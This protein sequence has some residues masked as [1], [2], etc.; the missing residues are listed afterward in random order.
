MGRDLLWN[1]RNLFYVITKMG[2][3]PIGIAKKLGRDLLFNC[4]ILSSSIIAI[5]SAA[6]LAYRLSQIDLGSSA[7]K[8]GSESYWNCKKTWSG[9]ALELQN[10]IFQYNCNPTCADNCIP[11]IANRS[12]VIWLAL[13]YIRGRVGRSVIDLGSDS[14]VPDLRSFWAQ[15]FSRF[16]RSG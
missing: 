3:N 9:S 4:K 7:T 14:A 13:G 5:L 15:F 12:G 6:I 1:C 2:R 11:I 10:S 16:G 8:N